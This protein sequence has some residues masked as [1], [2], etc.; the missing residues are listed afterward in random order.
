MSCKE[1]DLVIFTL[2]FPYGNGETF[3]EGE[4]TVLSSIFRKIYFVPLAS[5]VECRK[6]PENVE[7]LNIF[8]KEGTDVLS[9]PFEYSPRAVGF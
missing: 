8:N 4:L 7:V 2:K 9:L 5:D 3:L 6:T 1:K